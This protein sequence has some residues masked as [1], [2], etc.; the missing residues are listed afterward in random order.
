MWFDGKTLF[1]T[2]HPLELY[3]IYVKSIVNMIEN[4]RAVLIE[5]KQ[6]NSSRLCLNSGDPDVMMHSQKCAKN[7]RVGISIAADI[8]TKA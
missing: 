7:L 8:V 1:V 6:S 2:A 4:L 3:G 5:I